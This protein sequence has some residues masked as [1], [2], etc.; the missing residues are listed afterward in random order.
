MN[1]FQQLIKFLRKCLP[2]KKDICRALM[3]AGVMVGAGFFFTIGAQLAE[4]PVHITLEIA[5]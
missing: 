5:E 4:R 2:G 1:K 3:F